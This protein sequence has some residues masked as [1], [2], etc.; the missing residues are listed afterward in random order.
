MQISKVQQ[1]LQDRV[2]EQG[3]N[4]AGFGVLP[5][6]VMFNPDLTI[7]SKTVF[8]L[9]KSYANSDNKAYPSI[10]LMLAQLD[11]GIDRFTNHIGLLLQHG[12]V[13]KEQHRAK[14][15]KY[16]NNVYTFPE[17]PDKPKGYGLIPKAVMIDGRL[18]II[19]KAIYAYFC[20]VKDAS[21]NISKVVR[22]NMLFHLG[23]TETT[24]YKYFRPLVELGYIKV[25]QR[26]CNGKFNENEYL[27]NP[28]PF[29][30]SAAAA[31]PMNPYTADEVTTLTNPCAVDSCAVDSYAVNPPP[32][33]TPR[34]TTI[35]NSTLSKINLS[36]NLSLNNQAT[37]STDASLN[38]GLI[39]SLPTIFFDSNITSARKS[40]NIKSEAEILRD[41]EQD[42]VRKRELLRNQAAHMMHNTSILEELHSQQAKETA[43]RETNAIID[44]LNGKSHAFTLNDNELP[45]D[46]ASSIPFDI[47][48]NN[49]HIATD[50]PNEPQ[51]S[52]Q[53]TT[54]NDNVLP[55]NNADFVPYNVQRG[56]SSDDDILADVKRQLFEN[57]GDLRSFVN[58]KPKLIAAIRLLFSN[59]D[60]DSN[61][62]FIFKLALDCTAQM[63][64]LNADKPFKSGNA[65]YSQGQIID[66]LNEFVEFSYNGIRF[67]WLD[68]FIPYFA[69]ALAKYDIKLL[70]PYT[71]SSI[72]HYLYF[73]F[74]L[75][76]EK[77]R[78][79][80]SLSP[81]SERSSS[82]VLEDFFEKSVKRALR[83]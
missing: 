57:N 16:G 50:A 67:S 13:T 61:H 60:Y 24:Y 47:N 33:S 77:P 31:T 14:H 23:V 30:E 29:G 70:I 49:A 46:N 1:V 80:A 51:Y 11:I 43:I 39:D 5:K 59:A 55:L 69:A 17:Q 27:L 58:D 37:V 64:S 73:D 9:L 83:A 25:V 15:Q 72:L 54:L 75:A 3:V 42:F 52:H 21:T 56:S 2:R 76:L 79:A 53:A 32:I 20:V 48:A 41:K 18:D 35:S 78:S 71:K 66:K 40:D 36:D 45:Q 34:N 68:S 12:Y 8:A 6:Y 44:S 62:H 22:T 10:S 82:F 4:C 63:V 81:D 74:P 7:E 26:A 19:S 28:Y 38:D 65:F